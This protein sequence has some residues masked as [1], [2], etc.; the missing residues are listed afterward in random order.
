MSPERA[1]FILIALIGLCA[2]GLVLF[3]PDD[4]FAKPGWE[5]VT[6]SK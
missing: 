6:G 5:Q 1:L 4:P 2:A 3:A